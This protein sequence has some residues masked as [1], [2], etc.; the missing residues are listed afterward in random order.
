M[1]RVRLF[2]HGKFVRAKAL[3]A[4]PFFVGRDPVSDLILEDGACS[5]Q[6]ICLTEQDQ[7]GY[8]LEDLDS[9]N[10]TYVD[11]IREYRRV[12]MNNVVI[13]VGEDLILFEPDEEAPS[14]EMPKWALDTTGAMA[15]ISDK[16]AVQTRPVAPVIQR[17]AQAA[18]RAQT[19]PHLVSQAGD[20]LSVYALDSQVNAVGFGPVKISLGPSKKGQEEVLAEIHQE[21]GYDF[22]I[23]AKGLFAKVVVNGKPQSRAKLQ[24]GD[25][26]TIGGVDLEFRLGLQE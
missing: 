16:D 14:E 23:R 24:P 4:H 22:R 26:I 5:R 3:G 6:H 7:G 10:G 18:G 19:R 1:A 17:R 11:G 9:A 21:S 13:Q 25:M 2:R 8:L 12:L 15:K 20:L